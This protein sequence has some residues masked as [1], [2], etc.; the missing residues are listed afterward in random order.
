LELL[1]LYLSWRMVERDTLH[2]IKIFF[3]SK[4]IR[5]V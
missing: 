3:L 5:S 4:T 1:G 2:E